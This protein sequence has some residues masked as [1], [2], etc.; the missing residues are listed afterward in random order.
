MERATRDR[1]TGAVIL[2][3][4]AAIVVPEM[5]SGPGKGTRGGGEPVAETDPALTTYELPLGP[6]NASAALTGR[7]QEPPANTQAVPP[8]VTPPPSVAQPST[9]DPAGPASAAS[10]GPPAATREPSGSAASARPE[11]SRTAT[12]PRAQQPSRTAPAP[13]TSSAPASSAGAPAQARAATPAPAAAAAGGDWWVQ[14]GS[15][16]SEQNAQGLAG[17]MRARGFS[18]QVSKV[19]SGG[20]DLFRVRA[21]PEKSREAALALRSRLAAAGEQ[22]TLVAP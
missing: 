4:A 20:R 16:S 9:A 5:L 3:A 12:A 19:Q 11:D 8:P 21:G 6:S 1:L 18:I 10:S 15:F 22:G 2:V 14:L 17:R 13:A 7:T